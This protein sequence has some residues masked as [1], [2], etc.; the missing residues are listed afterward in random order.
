MRRE[1]LMFLLRGRLPSQRHQPLPLDAVRTSLVQ[2]EQRLAVVERK[3]TQQN[4]ECKI[5][6]ISDTDQR[7]ET[8]WATINDIAT[9]IANADNKFLIII[10]FQGAIVAGLVAAADFVT[11][12]IASSRARIASRNRTRGVWSGSCRAGGA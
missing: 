8:A 2:L 7:V 5:A 4:S 1:V 3:N 9:W 12:Q 11:K 6:R 10:T